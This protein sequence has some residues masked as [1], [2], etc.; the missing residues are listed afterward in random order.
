MVEFLDHI[1][2]SPKGQIAS[3]EIEA[4][5]ATTKYDPQGRYSATS[6]ILL[7][8]K[9]IQERERYVEDPDEKYSDNKKL[10]LIQNAVRYV[11]IWRNVKTHAQYYQ[12][13]L[14]QN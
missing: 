12:H 6:L 10:N 11:D 14:E 3:D 7:F 5:L 8:K 9:K 13:P 4:W 2:K 1:K